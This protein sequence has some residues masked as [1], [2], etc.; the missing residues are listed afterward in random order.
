MDD[1]LAGCRS[2]NIS[3]E[4]DSFPGTTII[5]HHDEFVGCV[6][7]SSFCLA[8]PC[9]VL[10]CFVGARSVGFAETEALVR[11]VDGR[12]RFLRFGSRFVEFSERVDVPRSL[13]RSH[14]GLVQIFG[15][16]FLQ[17]EVRDLLGGFPIDQ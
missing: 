2:I 12:R 4:S 8:L 9:L 17:D 15:V 6:Y 14:S 1:C 7:L 11:N 10:S 16:F 5:I 13:V 3:S